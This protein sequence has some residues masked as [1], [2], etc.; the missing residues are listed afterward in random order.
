MF[1]ADR[2]IYRIGLRNALILASIGYGFAWLIAAF[3]GQPQMIAVAAAVSGIFTGI[4][5]SALAPYTLQHSPR[6]MGTT[7]INLTGAAYSGAGFAVG[8]LVGGFLFD[9][10][11]G[12]AIFLMSVIVVWIGTAYFAWSTRPATV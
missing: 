9:S 7:A 8:A 12:W 10:F 6:N 4:I 2:W 3:A 1:F 11:G 5:W